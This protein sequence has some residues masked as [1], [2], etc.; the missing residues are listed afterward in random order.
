[1]RIFLLFMLLFSL[2]VAVVHVPSAFAIDEGYS[3]SSDDWSGESDADSGTTQSFKGFSGELF[4]RMSDQLQEF[5]NAV[6]PALM[7]SFG[8]FI[9]VFV[10]LYIVL[11]GYGVAVG[12]FKEATKQTIVS[13]LLVVFIHSFVLESNVYSSWFTPHITGFFMGLADFFATKALAAGGMNHA[14]DSFSVFNALD[15][16]ISRLNGATNAIESSVGMLDFL[17]VKMW[18]AV[19]TLTVI[20]AF[21]YGAFM[22][23]IVI[24]YFSLNILYLVGGICIFFAAFSQTR[25]VFYSWLRGVFNYG[26]LIVFASIVMSICIFGLNESLARLIASAQ[27]TR[28]IFTRDYFFAIFWALV[29]IALILKAPDFAAMFSG[30]QAGS[31]AGIAAGM[32]LVAGAMGQGMKGG[33]RPAG[34]F[35]GNL[36]DRG[37]SSLPGGAGRAYSRLKGI[38][39]GE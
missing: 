34:K 27:E 32:G 31:T 30:G 36:A 10:T 12:W 25:F 6:Y 23:I 26:L 35:V 7:Q 39:K 14:T 1:M 3:A 18:F 16:M 33:I 38:Y 2:S 37:L 19:I 8:G 17:K 11:G 9:R 22:A 13:I 20:Y 15:E 5:H 4:A 24:G 21:L 29:S 28:E